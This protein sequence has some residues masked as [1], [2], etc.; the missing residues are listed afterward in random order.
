MSPLSYFYTG[1]CRLSFC[2]FLNA[3]WMNCIYFLIISHLHI[4]VYTSSNVTNH[5]NT[6]TRPLT[7][8]FGDC[9]AVNWES[10]R[11]C[12][13]SSDTV[14]GP[15]VCFNSPHR[16]LSSCHGRVLAAWMRGK[17]FRP[18]RNPALWSWLT[19]IITC[20]RP[21][22]DSHAGLLNP[23]V[24]TFWLSRYRHTN[25]RTHSERR[26]QQGLFGASILWNS[27]LQLQNQTQLQCWNSGYKN[28][29]A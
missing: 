25:T 6:G 15:D 5:P 24:I 2:T 26:R 14:Q 3:L 11:L 22:T 1:H 4:V 27:L 7:S 20:T 23:E 21:R 28:P 16:H 18:D 17:N 12:S 13:P 8:V 9:K 29:S 10:L 19:L